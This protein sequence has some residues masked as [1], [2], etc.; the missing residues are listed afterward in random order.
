MI[1][2]GK[3]EKWVVN[4][5]KKGRKRGVRVKQKDGGTGREERNAAAEV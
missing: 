2:K 1:K 4:N 5:K 3:K